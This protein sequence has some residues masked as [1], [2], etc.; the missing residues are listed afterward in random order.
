MRL[1]L[2]NK[3]QIQKY[4]LSQSV[5]IE[6]ALVFLL[7]SVVAELVNHAKLNASY[8]DRTSNL[9]SSIGG[10]VL[11]NGRPITYKGFDGA[12]EGETEGKTFLDSIISNFSK[13]YT[14]IIVAGMEYATYVENYH[15]L[16]VLKKTE[17]KFLSEKEQ[18]LNRL[19]KAIDKL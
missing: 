14:V 19:K 16:N 17:L 7:E 1:Y 10:A 6:K 12:N 11:K 8:T 4:I 15:G 18:I 13:G 9:K 5:R 2:K 3:K